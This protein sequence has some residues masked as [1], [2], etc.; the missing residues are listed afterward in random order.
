MTAD[1][2]QVK[3]GDSCPCCGEKLQF[4]HGIEV[5]NTF[6]LGTKYSTSMDLMFLDENN[7]LKPVWMGCYGIGL[8]RC[9]AAIADQHHDEA[10]LKWPV[11]TAPFEVAIVPVSMKNEQQAQAAGSLYE[12][13]KKAGVE[14]LLDD[15]PERAGVKFKDMELVGIP[16]RITVGRGIADG[17]VEL[18][19]R[20][21]DTKEDVPFTEV[22]E[23]ILKLLGR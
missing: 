15:R 22:K 6:K 5:G 14:V 2:S 16:F 17:T 20:E 8:E 3:E 21:S 12:D 23:R 1:I 10:G 13:L 9:M 19:I 4:D 11:S 18:S 7:Q